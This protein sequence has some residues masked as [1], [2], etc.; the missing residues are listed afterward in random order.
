MVP[1]LREKKGKSGPFI[2]D[3]K[4]CLVVLVGTLAKNREPTSPSLFAVADVGEDLLE[5]GTISGRTGESKGRST[6][7]TSISRGDRENRGKEG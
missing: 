5:S 6:R 7:G 4:R 2:F 3:K 1:G